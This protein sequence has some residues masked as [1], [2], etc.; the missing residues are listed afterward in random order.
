MARRDPWWGPFWESSRRERCSAASAPT[1]ARATSARRRASSPTG[2][3][4]P[5][6]PHSVS[7]CVSP[8]RGGSRGRCSAWM[9]PRGCAT[10]PPIFR[11]R[12]ASRCRSRSSSPLPAFRCCCCRRSRSFRWEATARSARG[13]S[14]PSSPWARSRAR[15]CAAA[16]PRAIPSLS[17]RFRSCAIFRATSRR[18]SPA[19]SSPRRS[20]WRWRS[21]CSRSGSRSRSGSPAS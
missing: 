12:R 2:S 13:F 5:R 18:A 19:S 21:W 9:S 11:A 7:R 1:S 16:A 15:C 14:P 10:A 20:A 3:P 6:S 17:L 8:P 4:S